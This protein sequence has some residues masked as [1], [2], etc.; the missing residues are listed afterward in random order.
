MRGVPFAEQPDEIAMWGEGDSFDDIW[1]EQ[2]ARASSTLP[3]Q[4]GTRYDARNL[5]DG[6]LSTAWVEGAPGDGIGEWFE[7]RLR[8]AEGPHEDAAIQGMTVFNGYRKSRALWRENGRIRRLRL[9]VNGKPYGT[10]TL[11][12]AYEHQKVDLGRI[13]LPPHDEVT[14]LRF[15]IQAVYPGTKGHDTALSEIAFHGTGIY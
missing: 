15:T 13:P 10:I 3:P 6:S 7:L 5:C 4:N 14:V 12:D 8:V 1:S 2:I 9:D 11:A